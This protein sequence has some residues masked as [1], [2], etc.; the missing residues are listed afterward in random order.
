ME[1]FSAKA[2][3]SGSWHSGYRIYFAQ[4]GT[5]II[6]LLLGGEKSSEDKDIK[7]AK[8]YWN[9]HKRM[10]PHPSFMEVICGLLPLKERMIKKWCLVH[11]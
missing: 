2:S 5:R 8:E 3:K 6:L 7:A 11:Q 1:P 10:L 4:E 9:D